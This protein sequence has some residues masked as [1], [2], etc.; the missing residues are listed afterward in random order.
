M[1]Q[2]LGGNLPDRLDGLTGAVA[3]SRC[4]LNGGGGIH[5]IAIDFVQSLLF[6]DRHERGVGNHLPAFVSDENVVQILGETP[7]LRRGLDV[8]LVELVEEN[9]ALLPGAADV[10]VQVVQGLLDRHAL[11][12]GPGVVDDQLVLRVAGGIEGEQVLH[13]LALG[14]GRHELVGHFAEPLVV[15]RGRV[16]LVED[17]DGETPGSAEA[18]NRGGFKELELDV[19]QPAAF[20]LEFFNDLPRGPLA[21]G[22]VFQVDDTGPRVR[23][24]AFGQDLVT[25]DRSDRGDFFD[26]FGNLLEFLGLGVGVLEGGARRR[27]QD[28]VDDALVLARDKTSRESAC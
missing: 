27:L 11:L 9:E 21:L 15:G 13:F 26:F 3:G 17:V 25:G 1:R 28:R 23:A 16:G 4:T 5:V 2:R 24:A 8:N 19:G 6:L 22:P 18:G 14:Q 20:F 7:E 12:H 10:D